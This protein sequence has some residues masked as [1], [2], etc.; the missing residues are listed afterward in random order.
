MPRAWT[1]KDER[2]YEHIK[3]SS[4][5]RRKPKGAA[6]K[7]LHFV[8]HVAQPFFKERPLCTFCGRSYSLRMI[9]GSA[10]E[11]KCSG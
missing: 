6:Q 3:E 7:S 2:Q 9:S 5:K 4:R 8:I 11:G 1:K 10:N